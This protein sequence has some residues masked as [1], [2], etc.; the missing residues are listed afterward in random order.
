[1]RCFWYSSWTLYLYCLFFFSLK[2][3]GVKYKNIQGRDLSNLIIVR[4]YDK[5]MATRSSL[6]LAN[7]R[8]NPLKSFENSP[9]WLNQGNFPIIPCYIASWAKWK[10]RILVILQILW[11]SKI[12]I[13]LIV[14]IICIH[15]GM[16]PI[17]I[18]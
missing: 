4:D 6:K 7:V 8:K 14:L 11:L 5:I 10:R 9:S 2:K 3:T 12:S 17:L 18:M 13:R 15:K 16:K 1:M